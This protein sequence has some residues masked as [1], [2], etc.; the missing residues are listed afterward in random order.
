MIYILQF[1]QTNKNFFFKAVVLN[2]FYNISVLKI[3]ITLSLN[4]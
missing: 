1:I 2:L 4:R 3:N